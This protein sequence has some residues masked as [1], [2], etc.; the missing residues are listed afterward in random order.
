MTDKVT[1]TLKDQNGEVSITRDVANL[2]EML[3]LLED[4]LRAS[5]FVFNGNLTIEEC[6]DDNV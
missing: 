1:L 2:G 5:G 3:Q 6:L 4:A